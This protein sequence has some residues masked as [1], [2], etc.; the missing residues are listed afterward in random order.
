M[1]CQDKNH[2]ETETIDGLITK[3]EKENF[4]KELFIKDQKLRNPEKSEAILKRNNY[5]TKAKE[6]Q[7]YLES[8]KQQDM[9]NFEVA[10]YYLKKH[11]YPSFSFQ[12]PF[13]EYGIM[14][15]ARHQNLKRKLKLQP[16]FYKAYKKSHL[17]SDNYYEFLNEIYKDK[18]GKRYSSKS[19]V[20][21]YKHSIE[22]ML[23]DL[24]LQ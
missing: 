5:N 14:A 20:I 24:E 4:L 8:M 2:V 23:D 21:N 15:V 11:G 7:K 13:A 17:T 1:S 9:K 22:E 10:I 16:Y 19:D 12:D 3:Q 6:F 18:F